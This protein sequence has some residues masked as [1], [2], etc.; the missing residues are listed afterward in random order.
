MEE[1]LP[2]SVADADAL[3]PEEVYAKKRGRDAEFLEGDGSMLQGPYVIAGHYSRVYIRL[4]M[5][6]LGCGTLGL[7]VGL[8]PLLLVFIHYYPQP[9]FSPC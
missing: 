6:S 3:A 8:S 2:A 4:P 7:I 5:P 1:V 9:Q